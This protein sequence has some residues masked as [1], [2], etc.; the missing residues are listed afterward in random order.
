[1]VGGATLL[2]GHPYAFQAT[3]AA[4]L[5]ATTGIVSQLLR[6]R[7]LIDVKAGD[8]FPDGAHQPSLLH[9]FVPKA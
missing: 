5:V 7:R 8:R 9:S 3:A 6:A 1:M 2:C 4:M